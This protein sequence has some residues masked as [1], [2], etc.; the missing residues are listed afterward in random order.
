MPF[1]KLTRRQRR[2][3]QRGVRRSEAKQALNMAKRNKAKI[4]QGLEYFGFPVPAE[5][6]FLDQ[7]ALSTTIR[8]DYIKVVG[9]EHDTLVKSIQLK[10]N[11]QQ[12]LASALS[13]TWRVDLIC[14]QQPDAVVPIGALLYGSATPK[15]YTFYD[16][17]I[18]RRFRVIRSWRGVFEPATV[19]NRTI[20]AYIKINR[21][22]LTKT[23][24]NYDADQIS[25]NAYYLISWTDA[26]ANQPILSARFR[27]ITE[28]KDSA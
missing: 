8:A 15:T 4:N 25:K 20:D 26:V 27:T 17:A 13:D 12:N 2:S 22:T 21:K 7:Q 10:M 19:T 24:S 23:L 18:T 5:T 16:Y 6:A 11:V 1:G 28:D 9:H 3:V 14:D